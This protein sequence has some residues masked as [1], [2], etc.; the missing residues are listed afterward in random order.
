MIYVSFFP[1]QIP[2]Y[3]EFLALTRYEFYSKPAITWTLTVGE[4]NTL[5]KTPHQRQWSVLLGCFHVR[6]TTIYI[7][8]GFTIIVKKIRGH[9]PPC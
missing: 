1:L 3:F 7:F 6:S 8:S 2:I 4:R 9:R 5:F